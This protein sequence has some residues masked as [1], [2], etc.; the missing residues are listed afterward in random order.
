MGWGWGLGWGLGLGLGLGEAPGRS[1][2]RRGTSVLPRPRGV[3]GVGW[4]RTG[5]PATARLELAADRA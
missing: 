4:V 2:C 3:C 5:L 1:R